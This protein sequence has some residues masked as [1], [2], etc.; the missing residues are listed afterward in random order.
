MDLQ[1]G[2]TA[3]LANQL[4]TLLS[5]LL[6]LLHGIRIISS[7]CVLCACIEWSC[8][9]GQIFLFRFWWSGSLDWDQGKVL[10]SFQSSRWRFG[11]DGCDVAGCQNVWDVQNLFTNDWHRQKLTAK[12]YQVKAPF[13]I[14]PIKTSLQNIQRL[15]SIFWQSFK[16][17]NY[18]FSCSLLSLK[19]FAGK[20]A[21][22]TSCCCWVGGW[23]VVSTDWNY[24]N[25][26]TQTM[27]GTDQWTRSWELF[28][29][30]FYYFIT[31][32]HQSWLYM[33]R[34]KLALD[35]SNRRLMSQSEIFLCFISF[36]ALLEPSF[37]IK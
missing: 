13:A 7:S 24:R 22:L 20:V 2:N 21:V 26:V 19:I 4:L 33:C 25:L 16:S 9:R 18:H 31:W 11:C 1:K 30:T 28:M 3:S 10:W 6:S 23:L 14:T 27:T 37:T 15:N 32:D 17:L 12:R 34:A 8:V 29:K 35:V 36:F 5:Y